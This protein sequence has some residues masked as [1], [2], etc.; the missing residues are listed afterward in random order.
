MG[1]GALA[2]VGSM[3]LSIAATQPASAPAPAPVVAELPDWLFPIDPNAT[4]PLQ[5]PPP[6]PDD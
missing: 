6:P 3:A 2:A 5:P 4:H 1:L